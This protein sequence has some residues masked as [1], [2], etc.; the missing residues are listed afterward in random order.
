MGESIKTVNVR[1]SPLKS[2][3]GKLCV[4]LIN[5]T[6]QIFTNSFESISNLACSKVFAKLS[7]W[8]LQNSCQVL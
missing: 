1:A 8:I 7:L 6:E 2:G 3:N 5:R 4:N